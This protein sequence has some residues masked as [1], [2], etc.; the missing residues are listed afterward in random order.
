MA[1]FAIV[2]QSWQTIAKLWWICV[3]ILLLLSCDFQFL[4]LAASR[5]RCRSDSPALLYTVSI[6]WL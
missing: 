2:R 5:P 4:D 6:V 1:V 3:D